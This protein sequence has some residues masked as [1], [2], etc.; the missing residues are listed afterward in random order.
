MAKTIGRFAPIEVPALPRDFGN[1][2]AKQTGFSDRL[3][4]IPAEIAPTE[5]DAI[6]RSAAA[7]DLTRLYELYEKMLVSDSRI[8]GISGS[9][10]ATVS[11]LP[12]K[13]MRAP[14]TSAREIALADDY[15]NTVLE[16]QR[17]IDCHSFVGDIICAYEIGIAPFQLKYKIHDYPRGQKLALAEQPRRIPGQ[18]IKMWMVTNDPNW[19]ELYMITLEKPAGI[20][21]KD[22]DKRK[23]FVI[24]DGTGLRGRYDTLGSLRRVLG[25]WITKMYAQLWWIEYVENYGQPMRIGRYTPESGTTQ[26][27]ELKSF[28]ETFGRKKW[29]LFPQG[30]EIQLLEAT[31]AGNITTFSDLINVANDEIATAMV[32]QS[33]MTKDSAQGSR[34]Q[35]QVLNGVR[36]EIVAHVGEIVRK[37]FDAFNHAILLVNYGE[38]YIRRLA[39]TTKPIVAKPGTA[40]EK[41]DIFVNLSNAGVPVPVDEIHDQIG[42]P[43]AEEGQMVL[44]H[45]ELVMMTDIEKMN[46]ERKDRLDAEKGA[47]SAGQNENGSDDGGSNGGTQNKRPDVE[48]PV[49]P[50]EK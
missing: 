47:I 20:F 3:G 23:A 45:G 25:W 2:I 50:A 43:Q 5:L 29:G 15:R 21:F 10:K 9:L 24:E 12:L 27:A 16:A 18:S 32:G 42:I 49:P 33:G 11:G 19:G 30:A 35:L 13:T 28:L 8:G 7:G 26:R 40:K 14:T 36:L 17:H 37:G 38:E 31:Q 1:F 46:D 39:P 34:A 48:R 6:R 4:I 41:V 44:F 22:I